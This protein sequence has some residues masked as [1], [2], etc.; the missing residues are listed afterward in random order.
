MRAP[1]T[2]ESEP[3]FTRKVLAPVVRRVLSDFSGIPFQFRGDG[4]DEAA[5]PA[6]AL[7]ISFFPD[8]AVSVGNQHI[9]A[10]EVKILR[11]ESRQGSI[12]AAIGQAALYRSRY[13]NVAVIL[14][15]AAPAPKELQVKFEQQLNQFG[16][17]SILR[18]ALGNN[19][20]PS[21]R[22]MP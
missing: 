7:D 13:E 14:I 2:H 8:L 11:N 10:A 3:T 18:P 6:N 22:E 4:G 21:Y 19:L 17:Q 5:V 9:W 16:V 15:D 20:I 1:H 12:V